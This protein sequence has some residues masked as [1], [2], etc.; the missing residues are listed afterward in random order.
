MSTD[1]LTAES[2]ALLAT[3]N[4]T[5]LA[6][7]NHHWDACNGLVDDEWLKCDCGLA[8]AVNDI[9][10]AARKP[11]EEALAVALTTLEG[12]ASLVT[13]ADMGEPLSHADVQRAAYNVPRSVVL[14]R[15]AL[16]EPVR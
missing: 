5:N 10:A 13:G 11:L 4:A 1:T 7:G 3:N 16:R 2:E 8:Q 12:I 6:Y 14:L 9:E 15:A